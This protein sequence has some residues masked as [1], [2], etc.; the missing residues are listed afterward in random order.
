MGEPDPEPSQAVGRQPGG[1]SAPGGAESPANLAHE[2]NNSLASIV[3]FSH[4]IR[5]DPALP[6]ELRRHAELLVAEVDRTREIVLAILDSDARA[7]VPEAPAGGPPARAPARILV[8]DD[9]P[10]IREFLSRVLE[11]HGYTPLAAIDGAS[12]LEIIEREP[13][14]A[15]LCDH[16][17]VTMSGT[18]FHAAV[19]AS[20]PDL[21]R[22]FAFMSG[23]IENP[24]L[25]AVATARGV[26]LLGK[27]F[28]M[29]AMLRLLDQLLERDR[30][31]A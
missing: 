27:P 4:L 2:L 15:I 20:H 25:R 22:R 3:A 21:A 18:D 5:T 19:V 16:R 10:A 14:D 1:L 24:E 11:R 29:T 23:D 9:E 31:G 26:T 7:N 13:P 28:D 8:V 30:G 17:M 6:V 12:A